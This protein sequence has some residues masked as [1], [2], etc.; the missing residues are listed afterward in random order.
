MMSNFRDKPWMKVTALIVALTFI[1]DANSFALA[2]PTSAKVNKTSNALFVNHIS[3][4]QELGRIVEKF[5]ASHQ[6]LATEG[7][8]ERNRGAL[9][10]QQIILI[11]DLHCNYTAQKN[12]ANI[13]DLLNRE[14]GV[15]LVCVEGAEGET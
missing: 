13:V 8:P 2:R 3:V 4:P 11:Q 6:P 10:H 7:S 1:L 12:I 14:H 5:E 9:S 15:K